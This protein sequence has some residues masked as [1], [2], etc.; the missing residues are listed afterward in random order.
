MHLLI[1]VIDGEQMHMNY[2]HHVQNYQLQQ[3]RNFIL[4]LP[5]STAVVGAA[6][7]VKD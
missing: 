7:T 6:L 3:L 2:G 5:C 1:A 4:Y